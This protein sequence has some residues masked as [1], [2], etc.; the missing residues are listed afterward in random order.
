M[1]SSA[2]RKTSRSRVTRRS[3]GQK[4]SGG[5]DKEHGRGFS[6]KDY[7]KLAAASA[8]ATSQAAEG[9]FS[10][11]LKDFRKVADK[12]KNPPEGI[13]E[14]ID[15]IEVA[16]KDAAKAKIDELEA[17]SAADPAKAKRELI[18]L[19]SRLRGTGMEERADTLARSL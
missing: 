8:E 3:S 12:L 9:E 15:A 11:A 17:L 5:T 10:K 6:R 16:I 19:T 14:R 4:L 18:R 1:T 7:L 2:T 13:T